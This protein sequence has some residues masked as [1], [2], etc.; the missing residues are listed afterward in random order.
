MGTGGPRGHSVLTG[1]LLRSTRYSAT[2]SH[3]SCVRGKIFLNNNN[4]K[5][6]IPITAGYDC[7]IEFTYIF[8][9]AVF[10]FHFA[11]LFWF[12]FMFLL[13]VLQLFYCLINTFQNAWICV[14]YIIT[15]QKK[16]C[17]CYI[18]AVQDT[19]KL[20]QTHTLYALNHLLLWHKGNRFAKAFGGPW[21]LPRF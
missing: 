15:K 3:L 16:S 7:Q 20:N 18:L 13:I 9:K 12:C 21:F 14:T 1:P 5:F 8:L 4:Y 10:V 11:M 17:Q 6:F 19:F 2:I